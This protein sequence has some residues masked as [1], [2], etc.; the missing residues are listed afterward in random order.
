MGEPLRLTPTMCSRKL[1]A[2]GFIKRYLADWGGSPS[3]NEVAAELGVSRQRVNQ[4]IRQL[5]REG[6]IAHTRG[7]PRSLRLVP[8][9]SMRDRADDA[10]S[11]TRLPG[12]PRLDHNPAGDR[13]GDNHDG[14]VAG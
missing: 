9:P 3:L 8:P 14:D 12:L 1:Q 13:A 10:L 6:L 11:K 2:L 5:A 7:V 4:L